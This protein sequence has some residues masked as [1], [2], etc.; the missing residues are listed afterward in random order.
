MTDQPAPINPILTLV[1][2]RSLGRRRNSIDTSRDSSNEKTPRKRA[3]FFKNN[4]E[5]RLTVLKKAPY[6]SPEV[7]QIEN[8]MNN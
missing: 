8:L 2:A 6:E 4:N 1:R 7:A 5:L 3:D